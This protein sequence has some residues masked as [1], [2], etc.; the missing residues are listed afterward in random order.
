MGSECS[1]SVKLNGYT[2]RLLHK[3]K[4]SRL[5][6]YYFLSFFVSGC[7]CVKKIKIKILSNC[8]GLKHTEQC[9]L[10][11]YSPSLDFLVTCF[12]LL[13]LCSVKLDLFVQLSCRMAIR[14]LSILH[15]ECHKICYIWDSKELK[16]AYKLS[17]CMCYKLSCCIFNKQAWGTCNN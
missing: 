11:R 10:K 12:L 14:W 8:A 4:L 9:L 7:P 3:L 2:I 17:V 6:I 13:L 5:A 16:R 1:L 15:S